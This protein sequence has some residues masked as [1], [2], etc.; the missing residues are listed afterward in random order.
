VAEG[1]VVFLAGYCG[2]Y[3]AIQTAAHQDYGQRFSS[4][5]PRASGPQMY[6]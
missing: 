3:A 5:T 2:S 6:L 4:H 1:Q